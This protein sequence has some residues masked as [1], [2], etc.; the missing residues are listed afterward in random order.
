[1]S[2]QPTPSPGAFWQLQRRA[3]VLAAAIDAAVA[4]LLVLLGTVLAGGMT[5]MTRWRPEAALLVSVL[6]TFPL[7]ARRL[8][9]GRR[10][11][12]GAETEPRVAPPATPADL[13]RRAAAIRIAAPIDATGPVRAVEP[14]EPRERVNPA[15]LA[16]PASRLH[17]P[18]P[19]RH[20]QARTAE[21]LGRPERFPD[22]WRTPLT[23]HAPGTPVDGEA[24]EAHAKGLGD[25]RRGP[26]RNLPEEIGV[27]LIG[28]A[29]RE[30]RADSAAVLVPDGGTWMVISDA[31]LPDTNGTLRITAAHHMI[32]E[33]LYPG[34]P[35]I[36]HGSDRMPGDLAGLPLPASDHLLVLPL[37][38]AESVI[39]LS[40]AH[41]PFHREELRLLSR[42]LDLQGS[43]LELA[44]K[45][46]KLREDLDEAFDGPG[47]SS[48]LRTHAGGLNDPQ[49]RPG[50]R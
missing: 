28:F 14:T 5:V 30:V 2:E 3:V 15:Q 27:S 40:R 12:A 43:M 36:V 20:D 1:V 8:W 13:E 42:I 31:D 16:Q 25:G 33:V 9:R 6:V 47:G 45:M 22:F 26:I 23:G 50:R 24:A 35:R 34:R 44:L 19:D 4:A 29:R 48:G 32:D 7:L 11:L 49:P 17:L 18:A 10:A 46:R 21:A 39:L 37:R 38:Q 41:P